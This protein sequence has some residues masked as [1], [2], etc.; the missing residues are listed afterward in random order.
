[1]AKKKK[2][3]NK[4]TITASEFLCKKMTIELG[5]ALGGLPLQDAMNVGNLAIAALVHN[6]LM[7]VQE[8]TD[9]QRIMAVEHIITMAMDMLKKTREHK[10]EMVM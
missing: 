3:M 4:D 7:G 9:R 5:E 10:I 6:Y 2:F 8:L 1:M